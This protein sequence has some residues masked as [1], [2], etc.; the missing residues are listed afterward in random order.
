[1]F[2]KI[3][4]DK[5]K[6]AEVQIEITYECSRFETRFWREGSDTGK[7][8]CLIVMTRN[9]QEQWAEIGEGDGAFFMNENG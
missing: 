5:P 6:E 7:R 8:K 9:G 3:I 1:M 2:V 4:W